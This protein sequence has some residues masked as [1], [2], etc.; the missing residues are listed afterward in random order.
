MSLSVEMPNASPVPA[1]LKPAGL[2]KD[3]SLHEAA[4]RRLLA[5]LDEGVDSG[6]EK[7]LEMNRRL[8][9]YFARKGCLAPDRAIDSLDNFQHGNVAGRPG[10]AVAAVRALHRVQHPRRHQ[11]LEHL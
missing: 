11:R 8:M 4:F 9:S 2:K 6:G 7:Y 5:W 3:W 10:E 1:G